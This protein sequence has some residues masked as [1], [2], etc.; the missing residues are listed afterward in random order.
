MFT[1]FVSPAPLQDTQDSDIE[2]RPSCIS[3]DRHWESS[4]SW[5]SVWELA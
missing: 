4:L 1:A 3:I 2:R 5:S